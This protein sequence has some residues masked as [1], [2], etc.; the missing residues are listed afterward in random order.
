MNAKKFA[1]SQ[2]DCAKMLGQTITEYNKS[3]KN[4]KASKFQNTPSREK[5]TINILNQLGLN[6]RDLKKRV[7]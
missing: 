7:C 3:L 2:K 6:D 4:I 1:E 5:K